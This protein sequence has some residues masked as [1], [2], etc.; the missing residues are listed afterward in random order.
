MKVVDLSK[1]IRYPA[2]DRPFMRTT[3][4]HKPRWLA[5]W[6]VR[7]AGLPFRLFPGGFEGWA[8]TPSPSWACMRQP[9]STPPGTTG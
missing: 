4:R 9:I 8:D 1:P 6:L 5:R 7:A 2:N 3:V